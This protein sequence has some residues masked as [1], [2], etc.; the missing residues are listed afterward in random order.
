[1]TE[2]GDKMERDPTPREQKID[3][4]LAEQDRIM[5][6]VYDLVDA[7]AEAC[8]IIVTSRTNGVPLTDEEVTRIVAAL[9]TASANELVDGSDRLAVIEDVTMFRNRPP[10]QMSSTILLSVLDRAIEK[11]NTAVD[12]QL[13]S[14][15]RFDQEGN[16]IPEKQH[17]QNVEKKSDPNPPG[18]SVED[19]WLD[20]FVICPKCHASVK[21][22]KYLRHFRRR[23]NRK[24][25]LSDLPVAKDAPGSRTVE[26]DFSQQPERAREHSPLM[27]APSVVSSKPP[28]PVPEV[29]FTP[30]VEEKE[31][32]GLYLETIINRATA[33]KNNDNRKNR[34]SIEDTSVQ[35]LYEIALLRAVLQGCQG[36]DFESDDGVASRRM[37]Q[38]IDSACGST[39][40]NLVE[41]V[42]WK[43]WHALEQLERDGRIIRTGD[44]YS[45]GH[46]AAAWFDTW[47]TRWGGSPFF[48]TTDFGEKDSF[49]ISVEWECLSERFAIERVKE[50]F[51]R[52]GSNFCTDFVNDICAQQE[53]YLNDRKGLLASYAAL[54]HRPDENNILEASRRI[55]A[56]ATA[57]SYPEKT[58]RNLPGIQDTK[59]AGKLLSS[60]CSS[61]ARIS[62]AEIQY[63]LTGVYNAHYGAW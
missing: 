8:D 54:C 13:K 26:A 17:A 44:V 39:G 31:R 35:T 20:G 22:R 7:V 34:T 29:L 60:L 11:R 12:N 5:K 3:A 57:R 25:T 27:A 33:N 14:I 9:E 46:D 63:W 43:K 18:R 62:K 41:N 40:R 38:Y 37:Q 49:W 42:G 1:M 36:V 52:Y 59:N 6:S 32:R 53:G 15:P 24:V 10:T 30:P 23:H 55:E 21:R 56:F 16:L 28:P 61:F 45:A 50:A 47:R 51:H 2:H 48:E 58:W 19:D 4:F